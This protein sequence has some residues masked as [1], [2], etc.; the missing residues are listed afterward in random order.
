MFLAVSYKGD[1][2]RGDWILDSD[3]SRHLFNDD[4]LLVNSA[5]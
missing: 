1:S 5:A 3:A 4:T 2:D